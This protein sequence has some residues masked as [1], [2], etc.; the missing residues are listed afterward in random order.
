[1]EDIFCSVNHVLTAIFCSVNH[2]WRGGF[3]HNLWKNKVFDFEKDSLNYITH[4][5]WFSVQNRTWWPN[6]NFCDTVPLMYWTIKKRL[7]E[8]GNNELLGEL[9]KKFATT[10]WVLW[11]L[12]ILTKSE[13]P[14]QKI[15]YLCQK[16]VHVHVQTQ[17]ET[18]SSPWVFPPVK[19]D[20]D[21]TC[22]EIFNNSVN[23]VIMTFVINIPP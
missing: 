4:Q 17:I 13:L 9:F 15:V 21:K 2:F 16:F 14:S 1:M 12:H 10:P 6:N 19:D 7:N 23:G 18:C 5:T 20:S 8:A 3:F 22:Q 11:I